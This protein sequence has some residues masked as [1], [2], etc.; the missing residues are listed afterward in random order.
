ME[1]GF[2]STITGTGLTCFCKQEEGGSKVRVETYRKNPKNCLKFGKKNKFLLIL[3][4]YTSRS[5]ACSKKRRCD[6][7]G[8]LFALL[9]KHRELRIQSCGRHRC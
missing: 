8:K 9:L 2:E 3:S 1:M 4:V 5:Q 6:S 7:S